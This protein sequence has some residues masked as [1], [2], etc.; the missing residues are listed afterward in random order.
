M[1]KNNSILIGTKLFPKPSGDIQYHCPSFVKVTPP[2]DDN[3][4]MKFVMNFSI[5]VDSKTGLIRGNETFM[6]DNCDDTSEKFPIPQEIQ[7]EAFRKFEEETKLTSK[8]HMVF[9]PDAN[10]SIVRVHI[11]YIKCTLGEVYTV[12]PIDGQLF[13][14]SVRI[15]AIEKAKLRQSKL[16]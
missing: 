11:Q 9:V 14:D 5:W 16:N 8:S 2:G 7:T 3:F 12:I 6:P 15:K 1:A 4:E 13:S 10:E